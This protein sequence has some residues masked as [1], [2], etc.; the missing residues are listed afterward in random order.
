MHD[1][2]IIHLSDL[3]LTESNN[4]PRI[5]FNIFKPLIGMNK[6]FKQII[7]SQIVKDADFILI[8]GDITDTAKIKAW[9]NFGRIINKAGIKEKLLLVP[10]NHDVSS[11]KWMPRIE[12][13]N[14]LSKKDLNKYVKGLKTAELN[15]KD[16]PYVLT[17]NSDLVIIG[18]NSNNTGNSHF[19]TNAIGH[20]SDTQFDKLKELLRKYNSKPLKLVVTHHSPN[21]P[22]RSTIKRR[23][24]K[25]IK[26]IDRITLPIP[27]KQRRRLRDMCKEYD[28]KA[29]LHGHLHS[30]EDRRV[31]NVRMIG[32]GASTTPITGNNS[33]MFMFNQYKLYPESKILR[34]KTILI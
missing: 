12:V 2:K 31:N 25:H 32:V 11:F 18:L 5:G 14:Y 8:T 17:V 19:F 23:G 33:S 10:G 9:K 21:I 16:L 3:H 4:I 22:R 6:N 15:Y 13:K 7:N 27:R 34:R 28:V 26:F 20:I 29:I 30:F 24:D 1:Y